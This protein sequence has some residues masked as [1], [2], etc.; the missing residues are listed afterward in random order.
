MTGA[1]IEGLTVFGD[2]LNDV[3]M[4]KMATK[5]VAVE[6]ATDEIKNY[7]DEIIG[8]NESDSVIKYIMEKEK[9]S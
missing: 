7:A 1:C 6:N 3:N 4:F 9:G 5:A 8:P 2:N